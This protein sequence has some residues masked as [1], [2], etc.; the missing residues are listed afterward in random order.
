MERN[1]KVWRKIFLKSNQK[2]RIY[3]EGISTLNISILT[4]LY[5][6]FRM[7]KTSVDRTTMDV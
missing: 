4:N 2:W 3:C 1:P 5:Q 7:V 6:D